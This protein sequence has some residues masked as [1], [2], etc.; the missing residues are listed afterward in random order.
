MPVARHPSRAGV[1]ARRSARVLG[2]LVVASTAAAVVSGCG[3]APARTISS[4]SAA[5][6]IASQLHSR[7]GV[8]AMSVQCPDSVPARPGTRFTCPARVEGQPVAIDATVTDSNGGFVVTPASPIVVLAD[9]AGRVGTQ[10]A[11]RT[12]TRPA[13]VCPPPAAAPG[14]TIRVAPAGS[15]FGCT[16]TF[17]RQP[18]RPVTVTIVDAKGDFSFS[19]PA[20]G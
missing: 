2:A 3:T 5:S 14:A 9:V 7:Y 1:P 13:V 6:Q 19:L 17:G 10:I 8:G 12:G 11:A 15:S 20:A 4:A 16:A 18:P